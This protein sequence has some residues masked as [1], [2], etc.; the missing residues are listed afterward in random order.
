MAVAA[1]R[2]DCCCRSDKDDDDDEWMNAD[3]VDAELNTR[4]SVANP[5]FIFARNVEGEAGRQR[6]LLFY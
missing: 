4:L 1:R 3:T 6:I 5:N 2:V